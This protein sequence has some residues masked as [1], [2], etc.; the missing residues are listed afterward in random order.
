MW[1]AAILPVAPVNI[2]PTDGNINNYMPRL[3]TDNTSRIAI[4]MA[5]RNRCH[6]L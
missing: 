2:L 6:V 1:A 3:K 4:F 5:K